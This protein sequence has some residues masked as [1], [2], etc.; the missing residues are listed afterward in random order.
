MKLSLFAIVLALSFVLHGNT[1]EAK[2]APKLL[3]PPSFWTAIANDENLHPNQRALAIHSLFERHVKQ[4]SSLGRLAEVLSKQTW[5]S[6]KDV[7]EVIIVGGYIPLEMTSGDSMILMAVFRNANLE[8]QRKE[9][10]AIFMNVSGQIDADAFL[11][12][13][14]GKKTKYENTK[15][16]AWAISPTWNEC[17]KRISR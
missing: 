17:V 8:K 16:K 5:I 1:Q 6:D 12:T 10:I 9:F 4:D 2:Q 14:K 7:E 3:E 11:D 15:L 13:I